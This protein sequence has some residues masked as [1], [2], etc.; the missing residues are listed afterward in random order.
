[1]YS[2][3][4]ENDEI[5]FR[6]PKSNIDEDFI[7]KIIEKLEYEELINDVKMTEDEAWQ[8]SEKIKEDW[9]NNNK[10]RILKKIGKL[11]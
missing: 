8:I 3:N 11:S 10:D 1:M 6:I 9:W 7:R 2:I 5:V 4:I